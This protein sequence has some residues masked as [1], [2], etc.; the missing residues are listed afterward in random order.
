MNPNMQL[1]I[2]NEFDAPQFVG[3]QDNIIRFDLDKIA[4]AYQ[5]LNS[6]F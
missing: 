2:P 5:V 4:S 6:Q 1:S 3:S